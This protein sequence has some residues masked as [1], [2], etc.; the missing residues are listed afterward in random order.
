[1]TDWAKQLRDHIQEESNK[2]RY[3][4]QSKKL[5]QWVENATVPLAC[6]GIVAVRGTIYCP[7]HARLWKKMLEEVPMREKRKPSAD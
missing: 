6:C 4:Q 7:Y 1:V 2:W 5:C 3:S